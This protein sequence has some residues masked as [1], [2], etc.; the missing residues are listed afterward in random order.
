ISNNSWGS[1]VNGDYDFDSQTY[2]K[3]V[4]D[5]QSGVDG[6]QEMI[7][8][9]PAGNAG[10]CTPKKSQGIDSPGSAKTVITVGASANVRSLSKVNGGNTTGGCDACGEADADASSADDINCSSSRGPCTDGR[11]KPDLVAPGI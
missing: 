5:A 9:L 2:D 3:L 4:R 7:F 6:N 11:M 1:D 8:A 10:P